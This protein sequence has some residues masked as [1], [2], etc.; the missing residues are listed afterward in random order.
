[1]RTTN[2]D[3]VA[4]STPINADAAMAYVYGYGDEEPTLLEK[5]KATKPTNPDFKDLTGF[6]KG[7]LTVIAYAGRGRSTGGAC[8]IVRCLC[9]RYE[10][11]NAKGLVKNNNADRCRHC[12]ELRRL[13]EGRAHP[14]M[15]RAPAASPT[16][17]P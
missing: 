16:G 6:K 1:M 8:W 12:H 9:N 15:K 5:A 13:R 3:A 17:A 7:W 10:F 2:W 11:R 4:A 14:E